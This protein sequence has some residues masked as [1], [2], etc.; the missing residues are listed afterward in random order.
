[1]LAAHSGYAQDVDKGRSN[2]K[3]LR[4]TRYKTRNKQG[5]KKHKGDITGRKSKT[6]KT[7]KKSKVNSAASSPYG[8]TLYQYKKRKKEGED[9][10]RSG[11][12]FNTPSRTTENYR[13]GDISGRRS[14]TSATR[15]GESKNVKT[16]TGG[17]RSA[18]ISGEDK[19][20]KRKRIQ[21]RSAS[22]AY[23]SKRRGK[24]TAN[25][26]SATKKGERKHKGLANSGFSSISKR[27]EQKY[28][29]KATGGYLSATKQGERKHKKLSGG[30]FYSASKRGEN[31]WK[32]DITGRKFKRPA[33]PGIVTGKKGQ[34]FTNS[35]NR[36]LSISGALKNNSRKS[37][38]NSGGGGS[39]SGQVK[40][41]RRSAL[42]RKNLG[43]PRVS[44][45]AGRFKRFE[46][47][48]GFDTRSSRHQGNVK[49]SR[50]PLKG[51]G[52]ISN[53]VK[54][55]KGS[56]LPRKDLG[57]PRVSGFAGR[58][59]R[60]EMSP[61]FDTR[62]SRH[63]G[64]VK[65]SRRPLK[66]GGSISN[67]VKKGKRSALPRKDLGSPRVSGF[68]GRFK[69]FEMSPGFDTRSSRY[70]GNA[71]GSR[72]PLKGGGSI[73][74]NVRKGKRSPLPRKD[75]GSPRVS[76][77]AGRFKRF[78]MSPGFDTRSSRYQGN[79]KGS[80]KP[81]KGG[82]SIT[83][84]IW[85][86]KGQPLQRKDLRDPKLSRFSGNL[87]GNRKPLK[88]GGSISGD[89]WNNN[90]TPLARKYVQNRGIANFSG[91]RKSQGKP[92]KGGG[93]ITTSGWN[94]DQQPLAKKPHPLQNYYGSKYTGTLKMKR[95][96]KKKPNAHEDALKSKAPHKYMY[97]MSG[98]QGKTK[99]KRGYKK[100]PN[101]HEKALKGFAPKKEVANIDSYTTK[102][103]KRRYTK[104]PNAHE[105]AL[106]GVAPKR[107][108]A[109]IDSYTTKYAKRKYTKKP[110]A[111]EDA[112]KGIAPK[113]SAY[114][115]M[116]FQGNFKT[117]KN[118]NRNMHPSAKYTTSQHP[119]N[120][121]EE[122]KR[123]FKFNIWWAKLFKKNENQPAAVK[124]KIRTPRYDK[125]EKDLWYD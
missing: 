35:R 113:P 53:N 57:S 50:R 1:M 56:P 10:K 112:L 109:N 4:E 78:E 36:K 21:P 17:F 85:Q 90:Q 81:L 87:K 11:G 28:K 70:Q 92:L 48:P 20:K 55:G 18:S 39:V 34:A 6:K 74:N 82:G 111:H 54:K 117:K 94:N 27:G 68:A 16:T 64:N 45:F 3:K 8:N 107:V 120:S 40:R 118:Y 7:K 73:S 105:D 72:K 108:V 5:D 99:D 103:A 15:P 30:G 58:F 96:Y 75:L 37:I 71:K 91:N 32:K 88:G 25:Y 12:Y 116:A 29:G 13:K 106:K 62:S 115:A 23:V 24:T 51:G 98:Y 89:R 97:S 59:K 2:K 43:S 31:A 66:G 63:Q 38:S 9:V 84:K 114:K 95:K 122:K 67:N 46:M 77:F 14:R 65:G 44:G 26:Y 86:G 60:F 49:G 19:R 42:P 121:L 79:A 123:V 124:E 110:N 80:R 47:S 76:G 119:R 83:S 125:R 104:K 93:S 22:S 52:S 61:G 33:D 100:K 102:Y 69:R 101:A 41:G